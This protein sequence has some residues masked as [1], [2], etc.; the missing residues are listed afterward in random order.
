MRHSFLIYVFISFFVFGAFV[1]N[2]SANSEKKPMEKWIERWAKESKIEK[3]DWNK[4]IDNEVFLNIFE[5]S[6]LSKNSK[7]EIKTYFKNKESSWDEFIKIFLKVLKEKGQEY[8]FNNLKEIEERLKPYLGENAA[9]KLAAL[10][11]IEAAL[12]KM[13]GTLKP[14]SYT[15][16]AAKFFGFDYFL[17]KLKDKRDNTIFVP[18]DISMP[19]STFLWTECYHND[20]EWRWDGGGEDNSNKDGIIRM[21]GPHIDGVEYMVHARVRVYYSPEVVDWLKKDRKGKINNEHL[22][23]GVVIKEMF[24]SDPD[25][26]IEGHDKIAGWAVMIRSPETKNGWIWLLFYPPG[27]ITLGGIPLLT[28]KYGTSFCLTCHASAESDLT[29]VSMD[30]IKG[31]NIDTYSYIKQPPNSLPP[32]EQEKKKAQVKSIHELFAMFLKQKIVS[33]KPDKINEAALQQYKINDWCDPQ[34]EKFRKRKCKNE[35][36]QWTLPSN[37][38][39]YGAFDHVIPEGGEK[40]DHFYSSEACW[41]CHDI[42]YLQNGRWPNMMVTD[43]KGNQYNIS[44]YGEWSASMMGLSGRDPVFHSQLEFEQNL[45]PAYKDEIANLCLSCHGVMGQR[46]F[47]K[48][49][50][51]D[52]NFTKNILYS[53]PSKFKTFDDSGGLSADAKY[54]GL[55][56][57]GVSCTVCHHISPKGLGE[58]ST[59]TGKFNLGPKDE[60]YGPFPDESIK[61]YPMLQA[62][63]ITPKHG[64][65]IKDSGLCGSCHTVQPPQIPLEEGKKEHKD[66]KPWD[67]FT[68]HSTEQ[69]TWMEWTNSDYKK[70]NTSCQDCHMPNKFPGVMQDEGLKEELPPFKIAN[71]EEPDFPKVPYLASEKNIKLTPKKNYRRHTLVG[72]NIFATEMFNQ[73]PDLMGYYKTD[74]TIPTPP[75]M[76]TAKPFDR[77]E[78]ASQEILWQ[79]KNKTARLSIDSIQKTKDDLEVLVTVSNL[80]GHKFPTGVGFRRAFLQFSVLGGNDGKKT[81]WSSGRTSPAGVLIDQNGEIL[82]SEF[83]KKAEDIQPDHKNITRQ[84]QVQIYESRHVNNQNELTTSFL[85]LFEE[86]KDNRILPKGWLPSGDYHEETVPR[87]NGEP[88]DPTPEEIGQDQIT[89]SI[90][91]KEIEGAKSIEV[92]LYYQSIPPYYL[93]ERFE[94][95]CGKKDDCK[96]AKR[97]YYLVTHLKLKDDMKDWRLKLV[98]LKKA[99]PQF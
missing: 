91:L 42:S 80:A 29:F 3:L 60:V 12:E 63:G 84:D 61:T 98:T 25:P 83:T 88:I 65:Q 32:G 33:S 70:G 90:P 44:P 18:Y 9:F 40:L 81:L 74:V 45:R 85:G 87:N 27:N 79:A 8:Y 34:E 71:I 69:T 43:R 94:Q 66:A 20:D 2:I 96:N 6:N 47:Q 17:W 97:L 31:K 36:E 49:K 10:L 26:T 7:N 58:K 86:Y 76:L 13:N 54:G 82:K 52:K 5:K 64:M 62:V 78:L 30:N 24:P 22:L 93:K 67:S 56:R 14:D 55:A 95:P 89:Y 51:E 35:V 19:I 48:D 28:A 75:A 50:G 57:D 77:L 1:P 72:L 16:E 99:I 38:N 21:T 73:F 37:I 4:K 39:P 46:A 92:G 53:R 15:C 59:F 23:P 68:N 11:I 41:G